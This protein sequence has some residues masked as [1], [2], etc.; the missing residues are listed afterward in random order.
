MQHLETAKEPSPASSSEDSPTIE[1]RIG[2]KVAQLAG[3]IVW[4]LG[5]REQGQTIS[6][7]VKRLGGKLLADLV[8]WKMLL[9]GFDVLAR[10]HGRQAAQERLG[11]PAS[12]VTLSEAAIDE[13]IEYALAAVTKIAKAK[14][15]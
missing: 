9:P 14:C 11:A 6:P 8:Q 10:E 13:M 2:S 12:P 15:N 5:E 7:E 1:R 3:V 4:A